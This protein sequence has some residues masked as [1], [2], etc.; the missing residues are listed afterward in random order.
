MNEVKGNHPYR[1]LRS[2]GLPANG[3]LPRGRLKQAELLEIP[4]RQPAKYPFARIDNLLG[5]FS[6]QTG[7]VFRE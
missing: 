4:L 3:P 6:E 5:D 2:S 1:T 7:A